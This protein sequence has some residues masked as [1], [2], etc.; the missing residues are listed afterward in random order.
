MNE[1]NQPQSPGNKP[2]VGQYPCFSDDWTR[3]E[4]D[5]V[6][7]LP[8][9]PPH[10]A[11]ANDHVLVDVTPGGE[12]LAV[13][14]MA[15]RQDVSDYSVVCA[16][17]TDDGLTWTA[18]TAI[19]A[20]QKLG[21]YCNCGWPVMSKSGR[22]YVFYNFA[23]GIGEGFINAIMHCKYSDDDGHTWIDGGVD[24]PYRRSKFDH[25]DPRVLSRCIVWQKPI[26]DA[27]GRQIVPLTRSTAAYVKPPSKDKSFLECRCEFIRYNN[28]DKGPDPKDVEMTF[29]PD[30]ED[31]VR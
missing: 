10:A 14:T 11:E 26:R 16:R 7:Y 13:W 27:K 19:A 5:V 22:I 20:P 3:T 18:P 1:N 30:D 6:V 21:T 31:L 15:T 25:L 12:L 8:V 23:P 17:S 2:A 4:P 28:M 24:I 29:L 9:Q